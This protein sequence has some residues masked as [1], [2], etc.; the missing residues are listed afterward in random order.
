M[1]IAP[2]DLLYGWLERQLPEGPFEWLKT[3]LGQIRAGGA[4]SELYRVIGL[5]PVKL[6][7]ADLQIAQA[8]LD[9]ANEARP[10]WNPVGWSVDQAARV[11]GLL[12]VPGTD[13][14]FAA[15][16]AQLSGTADVGE[17]L[18][19]Y[20]GLPLYPGQSLH[21]ER[22]A[23]GIRSNMKAVFESVAHRNPYPYEQFPQ[24][25]WNQMV[26]KAVFVESS[27]DPII[28]L[29]ERAN[30]ALMR[31]LCDYAHERW[32]AGRAV[33][34]EL[35]RCVGPFA[36]ADALNDLHRVLTRGDERER[37]AAALALYACPE[38]RASECLRDAPALERLVKTGGI[39]WRILAA[40]G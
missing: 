34:R 15:R 33:S 40:P 10:G 21:R 11:L 18:A 8:D 25:A 5:A 31:M 19:F 23:E 4:D 17:L 26:L 24:A 36:D 20:R 32:A 37:Q 12:L 14:E 13:A 16:L 35:W 2:A 1:P 27:L 29:D 22:A 9:L 39:S 28:G 38:P 3:S 30:P 6:G 7:K